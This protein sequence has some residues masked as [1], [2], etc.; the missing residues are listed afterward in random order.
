MF[1]YRHL[2]FKFFVCFL[3]NLWNEIFEHN[4]KCYFHFWCYRKYLFLQRNWK[5]LSKKIPVYSLLARFG[6]KFLLWNMICNL[7]NLS[8]W[9]WSLFKR[10]FLHLPLM[11]WSFWIHKIIQKDRRFW[12]KLQTRTSRFF[13]LFW[14]RFKSATSKFKNSF[15]FTIKMFLYKKN[16]LQ[17]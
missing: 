7:F 4:R 12:N 16:S 5:I 11:K 1:N 10:E 2:F 8:I 13:F 17:F 3:M 9:I 15:M 14:L 6:S